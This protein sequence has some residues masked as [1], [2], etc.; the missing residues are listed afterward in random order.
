MPIDDVH[1]TWVERDIL[2]ST[3]DENAYNVSTILKYYYN[4]LH[5]LKS[6]LHIGARNIFDVTTLMEW[7]S[8][9]LVYKCARSCNSNRGVRI[10]KEQAKIVYTTL[11]TQQFMGE[12]CPH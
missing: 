9:Q 3:I 5:W 7:S 2:S 1:L 8:Q 12:L 6:V 4:L 11:V 10:S